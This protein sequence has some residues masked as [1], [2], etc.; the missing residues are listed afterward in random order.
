MK[1]WGSKFERELYGSVWKEE[2]EGEN[3]VIIIESQK[4]KGTKLCYK[5]VNIFRSVFKFKSVCV[6]ER[7][8][9]KKI[10]FTDV[11]VTLMVCYCRSSKKVRW[12]NLIS[13]TPS[14]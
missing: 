14:A 9:C 12:K 5:D 4:Q 8:R 11:V 6:C 2:S 3:D 7:E 13:A 10:S 1:K